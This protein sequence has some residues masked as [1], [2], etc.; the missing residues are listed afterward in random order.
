[1][2]G[3]TALQFA[4]IL[5]VDDLEE[6]R[7]LLIR[8]LHREGYRDIAVA[9]DG[10]EALTQLRAQP[11]DLVLL[12]VMMPKCDG[13]QVLE[14]LKTENRLHELP[15]IVI[16]AL[17]EMDSVVRCI[18]LGAV[19]YLPK[20]FNATLLRARV[21]ASLEQKFL[22]DVLRAHMARM[23]EELVAARRLQ[24]SMVPA[25]FPKPSTDRP[26]EIFAMMEPAREVGGD[27]YDFFLTEDGRFAFAI[28]DVC[29][30]GVPAAM[31]M[32]RTKNLLRVVTGFL[33][34]SD[35]LDHAAE[36]VARVNRELCDDNE[37]MMFVTLI[38]GMME[39]E[40]GAVEL[41]NAGH[42]PPYR[43][44]GTGVTAVA[45]PQG[46]ALGINASSHYESTRF[47]LLPNEALYL[48]TDGIT[49]ATNPESALFSKE[50][51]E[52][53]L[54]SLTTAPL[55][56]V[57]R[58]VTEAAQSFAGEAPQADDITSLAFRRLTRESF[59]GA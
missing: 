59:S 30:K 32:A 6:N 8:R 31:L 53:T 46:M 26:I 51:L 18:Q 41:C 16:S 50:R 43:L 22:R 44:S 13:Y 5:V 12:D 36:I 55:E 19:D 38:F 10:E 28:A 48:F 7:D 25:I 40:T 37:M 39:P 34:R 33:R 23:E 35:H 56:R 42:E 57:V 27:L 20:P 9:V 4:R 47:E 58:E 14:Q 52:A 1:M 3:K 11:F 49:E 54:D 2:N 15:V 17:G 45:T 21:S 29:G 24:M